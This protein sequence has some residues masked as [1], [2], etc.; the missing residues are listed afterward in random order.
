[1]SL[2]EIIAN[3]G[4]VK[5][6]H[7]F[8]NSQE[9]FALIK[10]GDKDYLRLLEENPYLAFDIDDLKMTPLHWAARAGYAELVNILTTKYRAN[11]SAKDYYGRTPLHLAVAKKHT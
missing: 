3:K 2:H 9:F 10:K 5:K 1:M 6:P 7:N 8:Y 4:L 11:P